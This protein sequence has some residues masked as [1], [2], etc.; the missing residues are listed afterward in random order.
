VELVFH[1]IHIQET[2]FDVA[3]LAFMARGMDSMISLIFT[4]KN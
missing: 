2:K 1:F 3:G 4:N